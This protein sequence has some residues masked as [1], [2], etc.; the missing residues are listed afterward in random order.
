MGKTKLLLV[1]AGVSSAEEEK[2]WSGVNLVTGASLW[3]S[4]QCVPQEKKLKAIRVATAAVRG[5]GGFE[6]AA[7][8]TAQ[9]QVWDDAV[10]EAREL[11]LHLHGR[12]K[13]GRDE[14]REL[15]NPAALDSLSEWV[16]DGL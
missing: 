8:K 9:I 5:G 10:L 15:M 2:S 3:Q 6:L 16:T 7:W 14:E 1:A 4:P 12:E 13:K 11:H